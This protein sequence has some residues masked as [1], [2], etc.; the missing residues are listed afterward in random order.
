MNANYY[1]S[2]QVTLDDCHFYGVICRNLG[3]RG[4]K[5]T[6]RLTFILAFTPVRVCVHA[7]T[8]TPICRHTHIYLHTQIHIYAFTV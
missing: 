7:H 8:H 1:I 6:G 4:Q 5:V 2:T 3:P